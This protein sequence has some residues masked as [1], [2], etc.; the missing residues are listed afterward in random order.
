MERPKDCILFLVFLRNFLALPDETSLRCTQ[1][2][3]DI[4]PL[5]Y[6]LQRVFVL[7]SR[8]TY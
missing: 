7:Q 2:T 6:E 5:L 8:C 4:Y 1:V 3:V